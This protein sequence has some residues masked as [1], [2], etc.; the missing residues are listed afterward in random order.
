MSEVSSVNGMTGAV[1]LTA[2]DVEAV[3]T[4]AEGKPSGVATL[5]GSGVLAGA[6]LPSSVASRRST[7]GS[8]LTEI[9]A[10]SPNGTDDTSVLA[11]LMPA[12][13]GYRIKL[14]PGTYK[15]SGQILALTENSAKVHIVGAGRWLTKLELVGELGS[16]LF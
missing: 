15:V 11:A 6:Q 9:L 8:E 14:Q 13:G 7:G 16:P 1:V 4:S 5:D 10:P 3:P 12:T 2:A